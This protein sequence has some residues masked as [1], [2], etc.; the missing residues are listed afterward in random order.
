[1]DIIGHALIHK[2]FKHTDLWPDEQITLNGPV[3]KEKQY[4][5]ALAGNLV[6]VLEISRDESDYLVYSESEEAGAFIW[7]IDKRDV[8][9]FIPVVVENGIPMPAGLSGIEKFKW[10][11]MHFG[12]KEE[13]DNSQ[14]N[15]CTCSHALIRAGFTDCDNSCKEIE[16]DNP[17]K[18]EK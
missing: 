18:S 15:P 7:M 13:E 10:M 3:D 12:F 14:P 17:K 6:P 2:E 8:R 16:I 5:E 11:A 1:M 4:K 9:Q